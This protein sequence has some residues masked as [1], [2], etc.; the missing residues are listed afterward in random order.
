MWPLLSRG[1]SL[2]GLLM[3]IVCVKERSRDD[4]LTQELD[5]VSRADFASRHLFQVVAQTRY[6]NNPRLSTTT[7]KP[8]AQTSLAF[9]DTQGETF[10]SHR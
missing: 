10:A 4:G 3:M 7:P 6:N 2:R 1:G 8:R 5:A 9:W